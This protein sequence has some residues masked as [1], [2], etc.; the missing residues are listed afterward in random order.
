VPYVSGRASLSESEIVEVALQ[1]IAEDGVESLSMRRLSS[2]LGSSLG[3]TYRHFATKDELL[4]RCGQEVMNRSF[5][6]RLTTDDPLDWL[7]EQLLNLYRNVRV[8]RGMA[9]Y[10]LDQPDAISLELVEVVED[11]LAA[12]GQPAERCDL[13]R[14][15]MTFYSAGVLLTDAPEFLGKVGVDDPEQLIASGLD[16]ILQN[17][18]TDAAPRRGRLRLSS[19]RQPASM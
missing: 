11:A 16:F 13:A 12:T 9:A 7:R 6:P 4:R 3:A 8:H 1:L 17:V 18:S 14:L 10:L 5:R 15:V 2:R 19:R